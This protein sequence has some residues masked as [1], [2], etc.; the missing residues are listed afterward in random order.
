MDGLVL[1]LLLQFGILPFQ[2]LLYIAATNER[3]RTR[4]ILRRALETRRMS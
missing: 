2:M 4:R 1:F 3:A